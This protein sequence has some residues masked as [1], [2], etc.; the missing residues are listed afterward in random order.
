MYTIFIYDSG[1]KKCKMRQR[2]PWR[3]MDIYQIVHNFTVLYGRGGRGGRAPHGHTAIPP[4]TLL[5]KN[6]NRG[7]K[8]HPKKPTGG[9]AVGRQIQVHV[10]RQIYNYTTMS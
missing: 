3:G 2:T 1:S 6:W 4:P 8:L 9:T 7:D 10:I 5:E